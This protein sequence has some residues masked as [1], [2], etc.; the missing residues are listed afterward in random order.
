MGGKEWVLQIAC[1]LGILYPWSLAGFLVL[2]KSATL[3]LNPWLYILCKSNSRRFL[4]QQ[5][6]AGT[7]G[8]LWE[9][10]HTALLIWYTTNWRLKSLGRCPHLPTSHW[11]LR[12]TQEAAASLARGGAQGSWKLFPRPPSV[13]FTVQMEVGGASLVFSG[14]PPPACGEACLPEPQKP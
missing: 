10:A 12:F 4:S 9:A 6:S 13:P 14:F 2:W 5:R 3:D 8:E 1:Y 11:Q 7:A